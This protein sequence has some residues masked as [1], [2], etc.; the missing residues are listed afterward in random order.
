MVHGRPVY[1]P[2]PNVTHIHK[3]SK[4][5]GGS[6]TGMSSIKSEP[7]AKPLSLAEIAASLAADKTT[8]SAES[9]PTLSLQNRPVYDPYPNAVHFQAPATA[10]RSRASNNN[11]AVASAQG[12]NYGAS[13][14]ESVPSSQPLTLAEMAAAVVS[15]GASSAE[16]IPPPL[17]RKQ[18][19]TTMRIKPE[20]VSQV[21]TSSANAGKRDTAYIDTID[22][23]TI[24]SGD[25]ASAEMTLSEDDGIKPMATRRRR[26]SR[27]A[28]LN[29]L[30]YRRQST[31][32]ALVRT[33]SAHHDELIMSVSSSSIPMQRSQLKKLSVAGKGSFG[34]VWCGTLKGENDLEVPVAIKELHENVSETSRL[35]FLQVMCCLAVLH[36]NYSIVL[37]LIVPH[38][39][40]LTIMQHSWIQAQTCVFMFPLFCNTH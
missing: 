39:F 5:R 20:D 6:D 7:S 25:L 15:D 26:A 4:V 40:V 23:G 17:P 35:H 37:L 16:S 33:P 14:A 24:D 9:I 19:P 27:D 8:S 2:Y 29:S 1:D 21:A 11:A 13:S 18:G 22:V 32:G 36:L 12:D 34:T 30:K 38:A 10:S 31:G 3:N 28:L